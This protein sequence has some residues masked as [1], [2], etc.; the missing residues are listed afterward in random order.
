[1]G[2]RVAICGRRAESV[3][4][5]VAELGAEYGEDRVTGAAADVGRVEE[6]EAL[7][8][9]AAERFG[10]I[11]IWINNAGL[12][13]ERLR[14]WDVP[15]EEVETLIRTNVLGVMYGCQ[16]AVRGM[17]G[18]GGGWVYN[19]EGLGSRGP[20]VAGT[21]LYGA[22]KAA[23]T[24][25]TRALVK[26]TD[27]TPV[28]VGFLSPGMVVTELFTGPASRKMSPDL[29]RIANIMA[30]RV[31]TVAP[32]LAQ[33]VLE[34]RKHGAHIDWLPGRKIGWRFATAPF[35]KNRIFPA[36]P[37]DGGPQSQAPA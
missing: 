4:A 22:S 18:Q 33:R 32:W 1:M 5:A 11:D 29:I 36:P 10:R 24:R 35:R 17:M 37:P 3:S 13:S 8:R 14:F 28:R 27:P 2:C 7:W 31:D 12:G 21:A 6:L 26:D 15:A 23:V 30:D 34:N 9:A 20:V 25:F 16:V 19:M